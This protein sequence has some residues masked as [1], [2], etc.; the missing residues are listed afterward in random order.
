MRTAATGRAPTPVLTLTEGAAHYLFCHDD[1]ILDPDAVRRMAEEAYR[2]NAGVVGPKLVDENQPDRIL[3]IGIDMDRFGRRCAAPSGAS[4]TRPST[5]RRARCSPS[6]AAAC[7]CAPTCSAP[8][9]A[10]TRRSRCSERTSTSPGGRIAGARV[11]VT[12]LATVR[13]LEATSARR[14]PLPEARL[15]QWRHELRAVLKNYGNDS[16]LDDRHSARRC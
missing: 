11:V 16:P 3:Q 14:R 1:V 8:L 15:L 12:P 7:S 4:S 5:T 13:H 10:S 9:A 2:S 6:Q